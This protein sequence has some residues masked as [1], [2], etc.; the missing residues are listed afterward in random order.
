MIGADTRRASGALEARLRPFVARRVSAP[1]DVD[2]VVQ[3][4]F[5]R[6][7]RGL[8]GLRQEERLG[9]WVYQIARRAIVDHRRSR[10]R[11]PLAKTE[12]SEEAAEAA[13]GRGTTPS[14]ATSR[15]A[16]RPSWRCSRRRTARRSP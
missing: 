4:V 13:E 8:A 10:A 11:H 16:S 3:E 6:L 7:Q 1:A 15:D 2:D 9:P 5:L 12:A 14:T